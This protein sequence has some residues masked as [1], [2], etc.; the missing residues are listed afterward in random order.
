MVS[1]I[2]FN[3]KL[4]S[5]A[6]KDYSKLNLSKDQ[7]ALI[8]NAAKVYLNY[9]NVSEMAM[10]GFISRAM[11]DW[12]LRTKK[13]LADFMSWPKNEMIQITRDIGKILKEI[14]TKVVIKSEQIPLL[15]RA[16]DEAIDISVKNF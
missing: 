13:D 9:L 2:E 7:R 16:I 11:R 1:S 4:I 12:Q 5:D 14:M 8:D 3:K 6:E 10:K 15:E